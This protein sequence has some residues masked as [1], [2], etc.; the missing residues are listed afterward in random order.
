ML[1]I[2]GGAGFIGSNLVNFLNNNQDDEI[3]IVEEMDTYV[4]K[5]KNL[6]GLKYIDCIDKDKFIN[7]LN[8]NSSNYK[9]KIS[10][11]FH[12]GACSKTTEPDRDYIMSTN[13]EYSKDLLKYSANNKISLIYASSASV[14]GEAKSFIENPDNESFLNHYAES[15]LLFDQYYRE[16]KGKIKSQVVGL[17]Y[18]NV[19]GPREFHKEGM[20]SVVYHFFTQINKSDNIKLFKGSHGYKDG[21]Q[22]RDFIHVDDTVN[23]NNWFKMNPNVSGIY[24]VGTGKCRTFND[25]AN[26]VLDYYKRGVINYIDFPDS[27]EKQYQ[28]FTEADMTKIKSRGYSNNFITL[29][30]GV[31]SY[32]DWLSK[33]L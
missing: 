4:K 2:T 10:N 25:I 20:F 28:A 6:D 11:I 1:V 31:K 13:L 8:N 9:D 23:V 27:L 19:F 17:R 30:E 18:F 26:C 5:F 21:E 33:K 7:D 29:E 22:R 24:N 32:L 3:L 12:L 16:H 15:K 14:Y